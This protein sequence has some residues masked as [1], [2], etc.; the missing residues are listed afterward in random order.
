VLNVT[1]QLKL[2]KLIKSNVDITT[3]QTRIKAMATLGAY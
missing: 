1:D 2:K 3:L